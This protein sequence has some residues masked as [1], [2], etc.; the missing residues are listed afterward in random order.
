MTTTIVG[1]I[2]FNLINIPVYLFLFR[3]IFPNKEE[4]KEALR[5]SLRP[6][7]FSLFKGE[8]R[9]DLTAELKL[10]LFLVCCA[11]LLT[12]EIQLMHK[13]FLS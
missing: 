8:L 12:A 3:Q 11:V 5:F 4:F 1:L 10:G 9:E 2:V 6:D 13:Y 7:I